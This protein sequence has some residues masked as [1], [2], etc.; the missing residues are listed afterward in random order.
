LKGERFVIRSDGQFVRDLLYVKDAADAYV[1][2]AERL[3]EDRRLIGEAFNFGMGLRLTVSSLVRTVL[4]MMDRTDL[5][6]IIMN[7]A[8]NEIREQYLCSDKAQEKLGWTPRFD[9]TNG[10]RETIAWYC[11]RSNLQTGADK[12]YRTA[13]KL[14]A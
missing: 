7:Q 5:E 4:E 11:R 10:L 12:E 8:S 3:A 9:L 13:S 14:R 1:L 6:P 2:V